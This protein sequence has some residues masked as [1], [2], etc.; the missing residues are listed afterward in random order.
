M[1]SVL[2]C[3]ILT[4]ILILQFNDIRD[5]TVQMKNLRYKMENVRYKWRSYA[6]N[7]VCVTAVPSDTVPYSVAPYLFVATFI[8]FLPS[9]PSTVGILLAFRAITSLSL[10]R[11]VFVYSPLFNLY[12]P[13]FNTDS[14]ALLRLFWKILRL[15][16]GLLQLTTFGTG[17]SLKTLHQLGYR[18][19]LVIP[20]VNIFPGSVHLL[21]CSK[22][23]RPHCKDTILKIRNTYYQERNCSGYSPNSYIHV[24][25]S[26]LII[27]LI[28]LPIL[29][30]EN[31]WAE[32]GNTD[33]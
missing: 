4:K 25:C 15:N 24:F 18:S 20:L 17:R 3:R 26:D 31:M 9:T 8:Y 22:I 23:G 28:D 30:Q 16:P 11:G 6:W 1:R 13:L 5:D 10:K 19:H 33:T 27:P 12:S 14:A 32:L 21:C 29:Q 2:Q 7:T